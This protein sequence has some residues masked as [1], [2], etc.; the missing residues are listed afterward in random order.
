MVVAIP[1]ILV[2][3]LG[4]MPLPMTRHSV[5]HL[6][7]D[8]LAARLGVTLASDRNMGGLVGRVET[9]LGDS[10]VSVTL[11][12][13]KPL[14]NIS[15]P[16]VSAALKYTARNAQSLVV[17]HDSLSH[18]PEKMSYKLGG[19]ANGHNGVKSVISALG[20]DANFH[21]LR[22]GIGRNDIDAAEYVLR[23]LSQ[24]ERQFWGENGEG[25]DVVLDELELIVGKL[26]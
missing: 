6:I 11:F 10:L 22:I 2:V 20:G 18:K 21:R 9:T 4:N 17:I 25:V 15:G 7:I 1:Q 16:S 13:P 5:G 12:K 3:G 19:S 26:K 23:K 14:M 8:S 24:H